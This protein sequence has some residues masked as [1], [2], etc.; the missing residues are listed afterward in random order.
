M[1]NN[2]STAALG[3]RPHRTGA[4]DVVV[5]GYASIDFVWRAGST[6]TPGRTAMLA[7]D[8]DP[9]PRFGGCGPNAAVQL[10][11][12]GRAAGIVTWLGDDEYGQRYVRHLSAAGVDVRGVEVA[13]GRPSPRT[14][15]IYD[16]SGSATCLYHPAGSRDQGLSDQAATLL[17]EARAIALTVAPAPLTRAALAVRRPDQLLAWDVKADVDAYPPTLCRDLL[18]AAAVVC[19]N[20]DEVG[21]LAPALEGAGEPLERLRRASHGLLVVTLGAQGCLVSAASAWVSVPAEAVEVADPT[22]VG[23][24]FFAALLDAC[25]SETDPITAVTTATSH[26][27]VYLRTRAGAGRLAGIE[28]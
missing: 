14:L 1:P 18:A 3:R 19:L 8:V 20:R 6:P 4:P 10:A 5:V 23:D 27:A 17:R 25:L 13:A 26:A 2:S 12:L 22:G 7:G 28:P 24:A 21:F 16:P 15:L 9:P 11:R